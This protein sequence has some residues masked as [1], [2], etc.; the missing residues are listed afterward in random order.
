MGL[1]PAIPDCTPC[2]NVES[3]ANHEL[4][5]SAEGPLDDL[6]QGEADNLRV[7]DWPHGRH[8]WEDHRSQKDRDGQAC[9]G[10]EELPQM[11]NLRQ[12]VAV[13]RP[14]LP[15]PLKPLCMLSS[16]EQQFINL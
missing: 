14:A 3:P 4:H 1:L 9:A 8:H 2:S 12:M 6:I 15:Y 7:Q 16:H 11:H 10:Q 13:A 5:R